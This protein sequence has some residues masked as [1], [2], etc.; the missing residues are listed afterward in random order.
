MKESKSNSAKKSYHSVKYKTSI[1]LEL[2]RGEPA[3]I[4]V[5]REGLSLSKLSD[6]KDIFI[7]SGSSGFKTSKTK[8]SKTLKQAR[9]LIADQA[10]ELALYKKKLS[11]LNI[12]VEK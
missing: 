6:W 4:I 10:M 12:T 1:V 3:E 7:E 5:R 9:N 8:E 2:L 11:L